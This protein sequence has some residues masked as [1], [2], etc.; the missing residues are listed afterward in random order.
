MKR[1]E[2]LLI[3]VGATSM[4]AN[5]SLRAMVCNN[6]DVNGT[7][8]DLKAGFNTIISDVEGHLFIDYRITNPSVKLAAIPSLPIHIEGG[9][10]NGY[11]DITRGHTNKDFEEMAK[12]LFKDPILT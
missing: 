4:K 12:K 7:S 2:Q 5:T 1:G 10:V 11:F 3:F 9:R 8:Y 6:M